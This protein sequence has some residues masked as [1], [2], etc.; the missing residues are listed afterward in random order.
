VQAI[1]YDRNRKV[2]MKR[3]VKKRKLT[4]DSTLFITME[5]TLFDTEHAKMTELIGDGMAITDATLDR[6]KMDEEEVAAM[7]KEV[8]HLR[9]RAEY[10]Q[11]STWAVVLLKSEFREIYGK[12]IRERDLFTARVANLQED[13]LMG[14][15]TY[16][17]MQRVDHLFN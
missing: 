13:T 9:H 7:R 8:D 6:A 2:V 17:D 1:A 11:N 12:I 16:K 10:Y 3:K 15:A 5:E 14:M 4:L